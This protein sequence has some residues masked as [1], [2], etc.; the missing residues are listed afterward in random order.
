MKNP[1][2]TLAP[3]LIGRD[4]VVGDMH[5]AY[6]AFEYLLKTIGFNPEKDR[7]IAVGDMVDRGPDSLKCLSLLYEPWFHSVLGNHEQMMLEK[8]KGG[9]QGAY[10][11]R[12]GGTWAMEAYNDY[13][14]VQNGTAKGA[15]S[16]IPYDASIALMDLLPLAEELPYLITVSTK[17]GKKFH[18]IH[19][20]LPNIGANVYITDTDLENPD[21]VLS[22]ATVQR[23]HGDAFLWS[24][25]IFDP[26]Y[27]GSLEDKESVIRTLKY[28][29]T[30]F[31][32]D[33]LSH[34]ISGHTIL[35]R[36]MT[37]IG[38]T[39]ID[40][41][42]YSSY[43]VPVDP[44]ASGGIVPKKWAALTCVEL[45]TWKFYQA[46]E[47]SCVETTPFVVTKEDLA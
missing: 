6:T 39:N 1:V 14:A 17:S 31:F 34:I 33:Q 9:W 29:G 37:I 45:D 42:A 20:E 10:W 46:T 25:D 2:K 36:P 11:Y 47:N 5:G 4:F 3:N 18:V 41:G 19:A 23:N 16:R 28:R 7:V 24:R 43:W 22:L 12:N 40:T 13:E 27:A 30:R 35:Q 15:A 32:N 38:Q 8:F 21:K 44:Y 26:F